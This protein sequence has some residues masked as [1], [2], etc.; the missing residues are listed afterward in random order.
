MRTN[1]QRDY[2]FHSGR[3]DAA[4]RIAGRRSR[5]T[6]IDK[7]LTTVIVYARLYRLPGG[8]GLQFSGVMLIKIFAPYY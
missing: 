4:V 1:Q 2:G 8:L 5:E 7:K 6:G 3:P